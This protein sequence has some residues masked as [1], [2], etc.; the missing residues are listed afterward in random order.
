MTIEPNQK[1][2]VLAVARDCHDLLSSREWPVADFQKVYAALNWLTGLE[3]GII[4]D[5]RAA[6]PTTST[7]APAA[8]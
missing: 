3:A 2:A 7:D 4:D 5:M 8:N 6:E 1:Q